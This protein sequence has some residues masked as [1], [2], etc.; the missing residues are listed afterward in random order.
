MFSCC[1]ALTAEAEVVT[2]KWMGDTFVIAVPTNW[3]FEVSSAVIVCG[4][5]V[6]K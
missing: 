5:D 2:S 4:P 6:P 3:L 1:P